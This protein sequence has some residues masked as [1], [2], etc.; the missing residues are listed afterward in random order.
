MPQSQSQTIPHFLDGLNTNLSPFL[1]SDN[2][3]SV[4]ENCLISFKLGT[5]TKDTGY[6]KVKTTIEAGKSILGLHNFRQVAATQK[7][8]ATVDDSTSD[9]T[10]LW[11]YDGS[12]NWTEIT[13]AETA[14]ANKATINVEMEDFLTYCFFV[15]WGS[16]DGF[17]SPRTLTG[18]TLGTTNT[19]SMPNAKYIKR[20]RD[21]LY[22][23]NTDI[24]GTATPYRVY[25]SSAPSGTTITWDTTNNFIDVDYS[26]ALMGIGEN[27]DR[28]FFFTEYSTYM[29]DQNQ[30][31]KVWDIGTTNHRTI[32][33]AGIYM[34]WA[35]NDG[36]W[37]SKRLSEPQN[38]AD[39]I[40][41]FIRAATM[42]NA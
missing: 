6:V 39:P 27:W 31:K 4:L 14:W 19:T 25:Y 16:T 40:K 15:G 28:I 35:N 29:Y 9:D 22:I 23:A 30:I 12:A 37:I 26:E 21:R 5:I 38:I 42:S 34:I 8:L 24:S 3:L 41:D 20:Y 33:N 1:M 13:A 36:V 18:T 17:I 7:M 11:Y 32:R 10:Q 2:T